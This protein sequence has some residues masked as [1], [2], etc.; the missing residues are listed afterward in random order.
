[1]FLNLPGDVVWNISLE[2]ELKNSLRLA[3]FTWNTSLPEFSINRL[4]TEI[5]HTPIKNL[6]KIC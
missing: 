1:M 4:H 6:L 3:V 5:K 2:H